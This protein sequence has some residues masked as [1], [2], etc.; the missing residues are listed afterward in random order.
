MK[1]EIGFHIPVRPMP[2]EYIFEMGTPNFV[3][4][5]EKWE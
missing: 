4:A 5:P 3:P 2:P 1:N